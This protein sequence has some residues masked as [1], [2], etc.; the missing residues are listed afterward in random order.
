MDEN[1]I[2][3]ALG[4]GAP[5]GG[6]Q[7]GMAQM[8]RNNEGG[9]EANLERQ[10]Q[11][12]KQAKEKSDNTPVSELIGAA[13]TQSLVGTVDR[14][15]LEAG[16]RAPDPEFRITDEDAK[17]WESLGIPTAQWELF[18]KATNKEH[19]GL[20][21]SFAHQNVMA[22]DTMGQYG[23]FANMGALML[24]PAEFAVG[25]LTGG[26]AWS[27][28]AGR[29]A[30]AARS[31]VVNAGLGMAS[32]AGGA[33]YNPEVGVDDV[34]IAGGTGLLLG[35]GLGARAGTAIDPDQPR[36]N[37]GGI[38]SLLTRDM[39]GETAN[40][41]NM[42]AAIRDGI[43][44]NPTPGLGSRPLTA[45]QE[46]WREAALD[47]AA[48][49]PAMA[50]GRVSLSAKM[51]NAKSAIVRRA[52]S[53]FFRDGVGH[54]DRSQAVQ[55]STSEV[56]RTLSLG[57]ETEMGV[58]QTRTWDDFAKRNGVS[59][60]DG[61]AEADFFT[62]VG[63]VL[64]GNADDDAAVNAM[65]QVYRK[66]LDESFTMKEQAGIIDGMH[67]GDNYLPQRMS[68]ASFQK[69]MATGGVDV[70]DAIDTIRESILSQMGKETAASPERA[71]KRAAF[72]AIREEASGK[73]KLYREL[74]EKAT[75]MEGLIAEVKAKHEAAVAHL[76]V[77]KQIAGKRGQVRQRAAQKKI[78][79]LEVRQK[80]LT[81]ELEATRKK[82]NSAEAKAADDKLAWETAK[83]NAD[84][85]G[86]N[87]ELA[88]AMARAWV[89]RLSNMLE[90]DADRLAIR[91]IDLDDVEEIGEL[92]KD[93]GLSQTKIAHL[94][95]TLGV[96][97]QENSKVG[98]SKGR[99][100]MDYNFQHVVKKADGT[101]TVLTPRSFMENDARLLVASHLREAAGWSALSKVANIRNPSEL[102]S[103]KSM[104]V[105]DAQ[106]AGDD[107]EYVKR[108][109]DIGVASTFGRSTEADPNS[110]L[111]KI[112][113][114]LR[115]HNFIRVLGQVGFTMF[116]ELGPVIAHGGFKNVAR[117]M[118]SL[119]AM[120]KRGADGTLG[121][122]VAARLEKLVAP[123]TDFARSS[124]FMRHVDD[125]YSGSIY[126]D[127]KY[128][129]AY[130]NLVGKAT[131][132]TTV[133]SGLS[134]MNAGLQR[135]AARSSLMTLLDM[136]KKGK[137]GQGTIDRL[138]NNGLDA[139]DQ[140]ALF[141]YLKKHKD[142]DELV[143]GV[144]P[145]KLEAKLSLYLYRT[146]RHWVLEGDAGD[147]I[148]AMNHPVGKVFL[149]F[150]S[151]MAYSYERHFLNSVHMR[152]DW[153]T[154]SMVMFSTLIAGMQWYARTY[155][156]TIGDPE[157]RQKQMTNGNYVKAAVANSSWGGVVPMLVDTTAQ[158]TGHDAIF[159]NTRSSGMSQSL[160]AGNP[161]ADWAGKLY[162]AASIPGQWLNPDKEVTVKEYETAAKALWLQNM[163]GW[164]NLQR[165][166]IRSA[167][168]AGII[169]VKSEVEA[170][171]E[172]NKRQERENSWTSR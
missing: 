5:A 94:L 125:P 98:S 57:L 104:V 166:L 156:N 52:G 136:S 120:L 91:H 59:P 155:L 112:G 23:M 167:G 162:G 53:I 123:G 151:F 69:L 113:R 21:E 2:L 4:Q 121:D 128:G 49:R 106:D 110:K 18:G 64:Y 77:T 131:R 165:Y 83:K 17:R 40:Q 169:P 116:T 146:S 79:A 127:G 92:L 76:E 108:A 99:I 150:R 161:T 26:L 13:M 33:E 101:T 36:M 25:A 66:V 103:Y 100:R 48:T 58:A 159:S 124:P 72:E 14:A 10:E 163:T 41:Q 29:L 95:H 164:Q 37:M 80:R 129:K 68:P 144:M 141:D 149:Q 20:L 1:N 43:T 171:A 117:S 22:Q 139:A 132:L 47:N 97:A 118:A 152:R 7:A 63:S 153:N 145:P 114:G 89:K 81:K 160:F 115:E 55:Y 8:L 28:K 39:T 70:E 87:P 168:D 62:R 75:R 86:I 67:K 73:S 3:A 154:Y 46:E 32:T 56:A 148:M 85:G 172:A 107:V 137:L 78:T 6:V 111:S 88:D 93:A 82:R 50:S 34:L 24:D 19:L 140:A 135:L 71:A 42:G 11:A 84:D 15:R 90:T 60:H 45:A 105:K 158:M 96:K 65:A 143:E 61:A 142:V 130:E 30:N 27:A 122:K 12:A 126:G 54:A 119:P 38:R 134:L 74:D 170:E 102:R 51:G 44:P 138:R 157:Q 35:A 16:A 31:G 9:L 109:W 147:G 133:V